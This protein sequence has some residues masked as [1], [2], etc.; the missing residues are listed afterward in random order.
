MLTAVPL[1]CGIAVAGCASLTADQS[2]TA[3]PYLLRALAA[4]QRQDAAV[5]LAQLAEAESVW[6]GS[7]TPYGNPFIVS[8]PEALREMGRARQSVQM[9]RWGDAAYYVRAALTHPS[10][11]IPG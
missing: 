7:N 5:A 11:V 3:R 9:G 2:N 4:V 10:T 8:D 1:A 6:L